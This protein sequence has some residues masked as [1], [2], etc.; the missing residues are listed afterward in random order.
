[1]TWEGVGIFQLR[2]SS[3]QSDESEQISTC[4]E[5]VQRIIELWNVCKFEIS[6]DYVAGLL[7]LHLSSM[8][9]FYSRKVMKGQRFEKNPLR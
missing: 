7:F 4:S 3:C 9:F 5:N 6:S 2:L 1:M 8:H